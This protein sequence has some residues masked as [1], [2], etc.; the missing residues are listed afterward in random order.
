M[1]KIKGFQGIFVLVKS[2]MAKILS[3]L[4]AMLVLISTVSW[5]VDKHLCM[6][7][8]MHV[9]IFSSANDCGMES[10]M[11]AFGEKENHC[12]D[13]ESF[14][15]QGQ[16]DLK[17]GFHDFELDQQIFLATFTFTYLNRFQEGEAQV[18]DTIYPPPLLVYD[19]TTLFE[20]YLI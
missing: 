10:A 20:V 9:A 2:I 1:L 11:Q 4:L 5:T 17:L 18:P 13:D 16:D 8:V 19:Y 6:G 12:C 15:M 14:T 7:R 3:P